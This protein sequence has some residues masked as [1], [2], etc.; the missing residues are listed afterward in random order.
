MSLAEAAA[1]VLTYE[2]GRGCSSGLHL[3]ATVPRCAS[4]STAIAVSPFDC[5]PCASIALV[6][7][8]SAQQLYEE[9]KH[10]E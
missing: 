1:V 3:A 4:Y 2:P 9:L 5:K 6:T 7:P 8:H 10:C